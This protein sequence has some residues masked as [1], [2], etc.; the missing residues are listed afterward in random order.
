[1]DVLVIEI[2]GNCRR[3]RRGAILE[4][5]RQI[6]QEQGTSNAVSVHL[7]LL[8]ISPAQKNSKTKPTQLS[9]REIAVPVFN[10]KLLL[11]VPIKKFRKNFCRKSQSFVNIGK[12]PFCRTNRKS[13][14]EVPLILKTRKLPL[15]LSE[16]SNFQN[17]PKMSGL[18]EMVENMKKPQSH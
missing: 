16:N 1:M 13:I 12:M 8:P 15:F 14:Y 7:T 11:P 17:S 18:E 10:R 2:G 4:A 5:I 9:V 6:R 3:Y